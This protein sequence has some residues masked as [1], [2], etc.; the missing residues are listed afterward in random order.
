MT[1]HIVYTVFSL[2][3][4]FPTITYNL[5]HSLLPPNR[6]SSYSIEVLPWASEHSGSLGA[7][8]QPLFC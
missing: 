3:M 7:C 4:V 8:A 1:W 5:T 2:L 6:G